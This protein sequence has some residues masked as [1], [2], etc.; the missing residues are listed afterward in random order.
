MSKALL[1]KSDKFVSEYCCTVVRIGEIKDIKGKD[2]IGQ[3]FVN[4]ES[5]V[6]RKDQVE[7]G[8]VLIY[9]SNE[10]Q[11]D[12]RFLSVNNLFER[13][14]YELNSNAEETKRY[15]DGLNDF[16]LKQKRENR[17]TEEVF[18]EMV[19]NSE[20]IIKSHVG[21]FNKHGRVRAI[22]LGGVSSMGYLFGLY[23]L[24]KYNPKAS[25]LNL[26]AF[27]GE[28]FDTVDGE[29]FVKAYVPF[30]E[31]KQFKDKTGKRNK[32][33]EGFDR[34]VKGEFS[35]HY[36]T[37]PL[38]KCIN[39]IH[40]DDIVTISLKIHGTSHICGKVKVKQPIKLPFFQRM[41]NKAIDI[42]GL[43]KN[44]RIIDYE[45]VYGNVTS[46]RTVIKNEYINKDVGEGFYEEDIYTKYGELIY[47][48]L[49]EGMTLYSEIFGYLTDSQKMIQ[50]SYDYGCIVG[51]NKIMPYR[52]T[53]K[54]NDGSVKEWNVLEVK[55]W[56]EKLLENNPEL[57]GIVT[58]IV[59]LYHGTL[60]DLYPTISLQNH[61]HEEV[62]YALR[63]DS[64]RFGM[65]EI[66]PLCANKVPREGIVIRIDNDP[67]AEAYKLKTEKF[68][69]WEL[70]KIDDG[71]VDMEMQLSTE[72]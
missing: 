39:Q 28:D 55:R 2:L 35:F 52:I 43:F 58:P 53:T 16:I 15:I 60:M 9:A 48:Y 7:E 27:V 23:E 14:C 34:M 70:K 37:Q 31:E 57:V 33:L 59:V 17:Y 12:K 49:D 20:N 21:F 72:T 69:K 26:E 6:V 19:Q 22:R 64:V 56:T 1:S 44:K 50:D 3:T 11:L 29:L 42:T 66:E 62:L 24:T 18:N 47:P 10:T 8:D 65:E 25:E 32:R 40:P 30:K 41:V 71:E 67:V 38:P 13:S 68:R 45:L 54:N 5:I 51:R 36:D 63:K 4:G 61:W 46:S